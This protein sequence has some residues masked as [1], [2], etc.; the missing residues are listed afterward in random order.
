[1]V[2]GDSP[3]TALAI[4]RK[5]NIITEKTANEISE[6]EGISLTNAIKRSNALVI[7]GDLITKICLDED[8]MPEAE[9]GR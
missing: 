1:M 6:E 3:V 5:C 8:G 9:K 7:H 2:T 4:A